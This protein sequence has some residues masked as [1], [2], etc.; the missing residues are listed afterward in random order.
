[1]LLER[2]PG[3]LFCSHLVSNN[4]D[5][6]LRFVPAE[7]HADPAETRRSVER[8]RELPFGVLCLDHGAPLVEDPKSPI[9][10]LLESTE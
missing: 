5:A 3:V 9:R 1:M 6:E 10:R 2:G 4:G 7:Y 8:L